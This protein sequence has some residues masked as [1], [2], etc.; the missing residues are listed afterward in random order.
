MCHQ[1][2]RPRPL[3]LGAELS[4]EMP[5]DIES[6]A[7]VAVGAHHDCDMLQALRS[8]VGA[9]KPVISQKCPPT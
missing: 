6:I 3:V 9:T 4:D 8:H 7:Q 2:N 1:F 5:T